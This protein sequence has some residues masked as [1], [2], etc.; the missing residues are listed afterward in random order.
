MNSGALK[1]YL[2]GA[3]ET[4]LAVQN[5]DGA[6]PWFKGGVIDPW[7]HLEAAMGLNILGQRQAAETAIDFLR[8]TQLDD[9]SWWGQLGNAVPIDMELQN[10]TTKN[11]DSTSKV[12]DT[13]F[14][15]YIATAIYH[16]YLLHGDK[17]YLAKLFPPIVAAIDFVVALQNPEGDIRWAAP[18][19]HT[20][21]DDALLAGNS[22]IYK[23]LGHACALAD[24]MDADKTAWQTARDKLGDALAHKPLRY[25]RQWASKQRFSMDWYYPALSGALD[26]ATAL[27]RLKK[28]WAKF[29]IEGYGCRCV[30]DEPWV[31]TAE[32]AELIITLAAC[33]E[34][35][36]AQEMLGWLTQFR[37]DKGAYWMGM[38]VEMKQF[39]PVE[40]PAWTA[41][42]VILAHDAIYQITPAHTILT[43]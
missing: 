20:K 27:A 11:M 42:A 18:D 15:A 23:S 32:S 16:H 1:T 26:K 19:P 40:Q 14:I 9:G 8:H 22:S 30:D 24:I 13:N 12:R 5:P 36:Q 43:H 2:A 7:N 17:D 10:F 31:T 28:D 39:W 34:R 25:D 21:E 37:D 29:V 33:G 4:I 41:G 6:I 35:E 38:Q 3:A